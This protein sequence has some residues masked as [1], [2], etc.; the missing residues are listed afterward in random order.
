[1]NDHEEYQVEK[2]LDII[3]KGKPKIP[4]AIVKWT[5]WAKPTKVPLTNI[6]DIIAYNEYLRLQEEGAMLQNNAVLDTCLS[7]INVITDVHSCNGI[8]KREIKEVGP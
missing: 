2:I 6:E 4:W 7:M 8:V 3:Y 1:M 5:N